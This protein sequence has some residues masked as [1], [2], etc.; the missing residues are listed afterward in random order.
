VE[1]AGAI[2]DLV[3]RYPADARVPIFLVR[4]ARAA[5]ATGRPV[6]QPCARQLAQKVLTAFPA[7]PAAD[8]ARAIVQQID[9]G[10]RG[11]I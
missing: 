1:L 4:T 6:A 8:D 5:L 11:R 2:D 3:K 7:A 9:A 10:R